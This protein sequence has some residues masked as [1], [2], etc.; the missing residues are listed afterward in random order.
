VL[1]GIA[2]MSAAAPPAEG[3]VV[4]GPDRSA[5]GEPLIEEVVGAR[6]R[7]SRTYIA[8]DGTRIAR[9]YSGAVNF[10]DGRGKWRPIRNDLER[11]GDVYVNAG[12][13][14]RAELPTRLGSRPVRVTVGDAWV[15]FRP[16]GAAGSVRVQ[17][18][19]ARYD[20]AWPGVD[21]LYTAHNDGLKEDLVLRRSDSA[22]AF[23]FDLEASHGLRPRL[24][25]GGTVTFVRPDG[26]VQMWLGSPFMRDAA[27]RTSDA[28][29]VSLREERARAV[30]VY[31]PDRQWLSENGRAWPVMVDPQ[32]SP[33]ADQDCTIEGSQPG[34]TGPMTAAMTTTTGACAAPTLALYTTGGCKGHTCQ[35]TLRR[36]LVR[37]DV[38]AALPAGA[39]VDDASLGLYLSAQSGTTGAMTASVYTL[40]KPWTN[41]VTWTH[42]DGVN[43]WTRPGGD[44]GSYHDT[45]SVGGSGGVGR[46]YRWNV[47]GAVQ[48]WA[49]GVRANH[50][51][52]LQEDS[53]PGPV[54]TFNSREHATVSTRPYV[55]IV[56]EPRGGV[57]RGHTYDSYRITDR[58]SLSVN[59]A[60]G[61][62]LLSAQDLEITGTGLDLSL[63]RYFN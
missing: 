49:S 48:S 24:S 31:E 42:Y 47:R 43:R 60:D 26:R 41:D 10:R 39:D 52:Q 17:G 45:I 57:R 59:I 30:L 51:F 56:Y 16:R 3:A 20:D 58:S 5:A 33:G 55:E 28:V 25:E 46:Y 36:P 11:R 27:G 35:Y 2:S 21:A 18:S 13:T 54:L 1:V 4:L 34:L 63:Q 6:T 12:N 19:T 32:V 37:F 38:D 44:V 50:G 29:H 22:R 15:A 53:A 40:T 23:A 8:P 61:N 9:V 7:T 62:L 14:Y